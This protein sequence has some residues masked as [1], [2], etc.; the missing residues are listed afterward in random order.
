MTEKKYEGTD[1]TVELVPTSVG[2][3]PSLSSSSALVVVHGS[4]AD[5]G[6]HVLLKGPATIGREPGLELSLNAEGVSHKHCR[7]FGYDNLYIVD[8]AM[9]PANLGVNP[10]LSITAIAEHAMSKVPP[11]S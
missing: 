1:R 3:V 8:G 10:S 7:V 6:V 2:L 11:K 4:E 5:L 9:I